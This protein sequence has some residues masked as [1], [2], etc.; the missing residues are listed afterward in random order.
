MDDKGKKYPEGHFLGMW[1]G[2]GIA[3]FSVI[4]IPLSIVTENPGFIGIGPA[5]GVSIGLAIGQSMENKYKQEGR[6]RP[7]SETEQHRK[8]NAVIAVILILA[9]GI[10]L[11][12]LLF[13]L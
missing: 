2:I 7:L 10:L 5:V 1:M 6:I 4:G 9:I 12:I 13:F 3:I 8:K 11:F